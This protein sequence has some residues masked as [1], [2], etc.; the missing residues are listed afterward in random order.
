MNFSL[1]LSLLV[2][3]LVLVLIESLITVGMEKGR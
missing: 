3:I 2:V 1:S